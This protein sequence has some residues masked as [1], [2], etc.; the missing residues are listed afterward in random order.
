MSK[1]S[2][3]LATNPRASLLLMDPVTHDEFRLSLVYERTERRGPVFERLRA[4]VDVLAALSDM[5]DVFRLRAAD[6]FRVTAIEQNPP[7]PSGS[8]P[9]DTPP[10]RVAS[11]E[12]AGLR[13]NSPATSPVH[14]TST[15]WSTTALE[16]LERLLGYRH[17]LL[18]LVDEGGTRLYTI[19]SRGFDTQSLGAEVEIGR[20]QIG[21]AAAPVSRCGS[22]GCAGWRS[23]RSPFAGS[24]TT[25][26]AR[27]TTC[28]CPGVVGVQSRIVVPAMARGELVGVLVA[29]SRRPVAFGPVD[30]QVLS[31]VGSMLA[32]AVEHVRGRRTGRRP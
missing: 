17:T 9:T 21:L 11:P 25:G 31:V 3:N 6:V 26:W 7:H 18:L 5:S 27:V 19:A 8:L 32:S 24:S 13:R 30:E 28:P 10:D 1:T 4:D 12:L 22:V 14:P 29:E 2:R 23:T 15:C 16:G 20:G